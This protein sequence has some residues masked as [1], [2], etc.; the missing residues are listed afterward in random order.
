MQYG[1]TKALFWY[2]AIHLRK[3]TMPYWT[4][5]KS[6]AWSPAYWIA[7]CAT[8][9]VITNIMESLPSHQASDTGAFHAGL[10]LYTTPCFDNIRWLSR[11]S[12][13]STLP[14]DAETIVDDTFKHKA[15][16]SAEVRIEAERRLRKKLDYRLMPT[17]VVICMM[18]YIDVR[19]DFIFPLILCYLLLPTILASRDHSREIK[20]PSVRPGFD[21]Y[22]FSWR[23]NFSHF[24][25]RC[26]IW[27]CDRH[28]LC[29]VLPCANSVKYGRL[30]YTK[31]L[32]FLIDHIFVRF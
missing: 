11:L 21:R 9:A 20:G 29:L 1:E 18:N 19:D 32:P 3:K 17:I 31:L 5:D 14:L 2:V 25:P 28:P 24:Q 13:S 10:C 4:I 6:K 12:M 22:T 26:A 27:H 15:V 7:C 16:L 8:T 30:Y 23:Q